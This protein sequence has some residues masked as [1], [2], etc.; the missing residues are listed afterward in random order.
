MGLNLNKFIALK[1]KTIKVPAWDNEE[2]KIRA[3]SSYE[4]I[5]VFEKYDFE[6]P[7]E[8]VK[9]SY[10]ILAIAS[11]EPKISLDELKKISTPAEVISGLAAEVIELSTKKQK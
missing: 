4:M 1:E 3:L 8:Q 5:E 7:P 2:I 10:E 6:L 9:A 11:V